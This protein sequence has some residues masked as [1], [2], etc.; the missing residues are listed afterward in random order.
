MSEENS[1]GHKLPAGGTQRRKTPWPLMI[2]AALFVVVPFAYWYGTWF[3]RE[4]SDEKIEE[5]LRDEKNPRHVQHALQQIAEKIEKGKPGVER[6]FPRVVEACASPVADVRMTAAW[7]MGIEHRREEF[8]AALLRLLEDAEPI[9]RRNAALALVR[10]GDASCREELRAMLKPYTVASPASGSALTVLTE[11][12]VVKRETMLAR[13]RMEG[14]KIEEVRAPLPGKISK[15]SIKEGDRVEQGSEVFVIAPDS[16][17]VR[18]A[19]IGLYYF[20]EEKDLPEIERYAAGVE[21][22]SE[23][24]KK[25]AAMTVEAVRRRSSVKS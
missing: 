17:S 21:G 15:A 2:V 14:E 5:Y 10:F 23:Q 9:V 1:N 18:D 8:R 19:L 12:S 16:E 3:G 24:V 6:W 4:L 13:I 25:Q 20:G 7:V 22:M 11:G